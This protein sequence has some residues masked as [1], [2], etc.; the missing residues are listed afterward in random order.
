LGDEI[1]EWTNATNVLCVHFM[2]LMQ[3][4]HFKTLCKHVHY[5]S[6]NYNFGFS[7]TLADSMDQELLEKLKVT[8]PIVFF[9]SSGASTPFPQS[10]HSYS[11][12]FSPQL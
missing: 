11:Q 12:L 7:V 10:P 5:L 8:K 6:V 2:H 1:C 9:V 3:K 4:L